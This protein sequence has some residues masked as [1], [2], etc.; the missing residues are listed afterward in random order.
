MRR[1]RPS[2]MPAARNSRCRIGARVGSW[3]RDRGA[4]APRG[5]SPRMLRPGLVP[6]CQDI[7]RCDAASRVRPR[8]ASWASTVRP[9]REL[10]AD[11]RHT[12]CHGG[13]GG[14]RRRR[15]RRRRRPNRRVPSEPEQRARQAAHRRHARDALGCRGRA[16]VPQARRPRRGARGARQPPRVCAHAGHGL[17]RA[18]R[19]VL[20]HTVVGRARMPPPP[21][22][23]Q[24]PMTDYPAG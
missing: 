23:G 9:L 10:P 6:S 1:P 4:C 5:G 19:R 14:R 12:E 16:R 18:A 22:D 15:R 20:P 17:E 2:P 24:T 11:R 7:R 13:G 3:P 8:R 21:E